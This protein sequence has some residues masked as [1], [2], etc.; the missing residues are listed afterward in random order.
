MSKERKQRK[1]PK[2]AKEIEVKDLRFKLGGAGQVVNFNRLIEHL[3]TKTG[4]DSKEEHTYM[5]FT[6]ADWD[7]DND[8]A[9]PTLKV[10]TETDA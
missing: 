1:P 10:S 4:Q 6:G 5:V 9:K 3:K 7:H 2:K 8:P